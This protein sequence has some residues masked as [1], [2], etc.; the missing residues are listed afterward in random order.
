MPPRDSDYAPYALTTDESRF[1]LGQTSISNSLGTAIARSRRTN[2]SNRATIFLHGATGSWS[3]WTPLL[4][5][6]DADAITI[7]NPVLLDLPCW[8]DGTITTVGTDSVLEAACSLVRECAESLGYTEWDLIGHSMGGFIA[9]H[10]AAKWPE[11]VMSVGT[12][13]ATGWA[14]I[15]VVEHP[16]RRFWS[17]PG[18]VMLSRLMRIL[19]GFGDAGRAPVR[20]LR[21]IGLLRLVVIPLI[22]HPFR[23]PATVIDALAD[24][25]RP[26]AFST[27]VNLVRGYD[28]AATWSR[29]ECPVR[30]TQGDRDVFSRAA[31]LDSLGR[32]LPDCFRHLLD[33]CGHFGAVERPREVLA[34]LGYTP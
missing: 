23:M 25:V 9:L 15:D 10:M 32:I 33:G 17:L 28:A 16:I 1:G 27:T 3:T 24:E 19:S 30:A 31:D 7:A 4:A 8:G 29:I 6:A 13:S 14:V 21:S 20:F 22:R 5:A 18:F 2:R 34:A 12:V 11:S 26:R